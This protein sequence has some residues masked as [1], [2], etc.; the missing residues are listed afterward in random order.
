MFLVYIWKVLHFHEYYVQKCIPPPIVSIGLN[1]ATI[2]ATFHHI[3]VCVK[4]QPAPRQNLNVTLFKSVI[5]LS[6]GF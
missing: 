4:T 1:T 3:S 6:T 5:W 2:N